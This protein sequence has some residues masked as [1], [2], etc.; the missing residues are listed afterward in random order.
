[1]ILL[2]A[3][4]VASACVALFCGLA[5]GTGA[6]PFWVFFR[7]RGAYQSTGLARDRALAEAFAKVTPRALARRAKATRERNPGRALPANAVDLLDCPPDPAYVAAV[8]AAGGSIR[9]TSAWL[10]TVSIDASPDAI[11]RINRLPCVAH[12]QPVASQKPDA[13]DTANTDFDAGPSCVQIDML[14][15]PEAQA[16]GL[17]GHGVLICVL[18][19]GFDLDHEAFRQLEVRAERDFVFND[20]DPSYDPRTDSPSQSNHGTT[21]LS[22]IAAYAPG[23][24]IGPAYCADYLLGKTEVIDAELPVEEDYWCEGVEWAE[25]EGAD[26]LSSSL[27][28]RNWYRASDLDGRTAV[29]TRTANLAL[30]R[31]L[32]IVEAMGNDGPKEGTLS[33]PA[34]APGVISVGSVDGI[35][36]LTGFS[37]AGPTYDRRVKP[38]LV[39]PGSAVVVVAPRTPDRYQ[40]GSGT[41]YSAPLVAGCA[42]LVMEAHPDWGPEAVREAL[43]MSGNRADR[44][45][46]HYGWGIVN[47]RDAVLYPLLEGRVTDFHTGEPLRNARIRW[48]P[49]AAGSV[50]SLG[51]APSDSPPRGE[52]RSDSTGAYVIPNL[53]RG[54]YT[55][56]VSKEGYFDAA[57]GP[58]DVP[59]NLGDVNFA[60]RYR[61]E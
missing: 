19:S 32:L 9:T 29:T 13:E 4:L 50:D 7:D 8:T 25:A 46:N 37:S 44:P 24:L 39:A 55:I 26:L 15:I 60:L 17:C 21:V 12:T 10:N 41:S 43:A 14:H 18:D 59:P 2:R 5:E 45:D 16:M 40:R 58:Y 35:G 33:A 49:A 48:R 28:Y 27:S 61:G 34:D 11:A 1:M 3:W 20:D 57:A 6:Q 31:G 22:M 53:P 47:A 42:A 51:A 54:S 36:N 56:E 38:D 23:H 52:V 30:E